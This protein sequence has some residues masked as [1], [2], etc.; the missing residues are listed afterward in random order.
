LGNWE[1]GKLGNCVEGEM[2]MSEREGWQSIE[3]FEMFEQLERLSDEIW[4]VVLTWH[5]LAQD[6]VGK[7]LIRAADSIGANLVEGDGRY[8]FK[9]KLHFCYIARGSLKE[10]RRWLQR[11]RVRR[12][13]TPEQAEN[14]IN[15][16]DS[17][18][19]WL[20]TIISQRRQWASQVREEPA[21]YKTS[22]EETGELGD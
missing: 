4:D 21:E 6:T 13:L 12:L 8:S 22:N 7:Q 10:T 1:I 5:S 16:A 15:R 3:N 11:A 20:N 2:M 9:D 18:L 17:G 19:R 14:Y